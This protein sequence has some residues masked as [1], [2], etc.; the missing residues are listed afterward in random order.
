VEMS[1][2]EGETGNEISSCLERMFTP[3]ERKIKGA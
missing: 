1:H 3:H 2:D